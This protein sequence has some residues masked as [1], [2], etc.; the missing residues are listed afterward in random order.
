VEA[1]ETEEVTVE[2]GAPQGHVPDIEEL[3]NAYMP[4]VR[5]VVSRIAAG[6]DHTTYLDYEDLVAFGAQGLVEAYRNFDPTRGVKFSTYA[7]TRIRGSVLDALRSARPLPRSLQRAGAAVDRAASDLATSLGHSPSMS[8][9]A[10]HMG[11]P[12]DKVRDAARATELKVTS[13]ER[14]AELGWQRST[15]RMMEV[16]DDDE[17]VDP[18]AVAMNS[19]LLGRLRAGIATLP[20]RERAVIEMYY[21]KSLPLKTVGKVLDVSESRA[22]QLRHR[23]IRRLRDYLS[24]EVEAEA[25]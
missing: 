3:G 17:N 12:L 5:Y 24:Y 16:A 23:A 1:R 20:P 18:E 8:E 7:L 22:S 4:L 19:V 25:A 11:L 21:V 2:G 14:M 6:K 9:I 15:E 10:G 13:L